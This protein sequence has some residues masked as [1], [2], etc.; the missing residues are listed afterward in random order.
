MLPMVKKM[1][2]LR[3]CRVMKRMRD[4]DNEAEKVHNDDNDAANGDKD[5]E[6]EDVHNDEQAAVN[7]EKEDEAEAIQ[8]EEEDAASCATNED[9]LLFENMQGNEAEGIKFVPNM[10][11]L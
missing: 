7:N 8:Y 1:M 11:M 3:K 2:S 4:K 6:A 10:G 9:D 5:D